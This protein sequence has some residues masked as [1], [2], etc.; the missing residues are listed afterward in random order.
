MNLTRTAIVRLMLATAAWGLSF[1][2]AKAVIHGILSR[3][4]LTPTD[5][6]LVI[7]TGVNA[8]SWPILLSH[9]GAKSV[10]TGINR[11]RL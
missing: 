11:A 5:I 10:K 8:S 9:V 4:C 1:P 6:D 2:T 7:P 3:A